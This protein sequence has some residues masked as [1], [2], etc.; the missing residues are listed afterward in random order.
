MDSR[1]LEYFVRIAEL[2]SINRAA[3]DLHIS[4][5][6]LSRHV[7]RLEHEMRASLFTRTRGGVRLTESGRLLADRVRPLL[8]QFATL[9]EEVGEQAAGQLSIGMP[10]PWIHLVAQPFVARYRIAQPA[11]RL[12]VHEGV[13]HLLRDQ[14]LAGTLD[15]CVLPVEAAP[16]PG[17]TQAA[18]LREPLVL[19][20]ARA[21]PSRPH[22]RT[23]RARGGASRAQASA[24]LPLATADA[25]PL[26]MPGPANPLRQQ[27]ETA[28]ARERLR[29]R[30]AVETDTL[31]MCLALAARGVG[32]TVV[33]A[34][35][36]QGAAPAAVD[37]DAV[38]WAPLGTLAVTWALAANA[39]RAHSLAVRE[40]ER[41]LDAVAR[42][43]ATGGA[44]PGAVRVG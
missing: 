13:S 7:A 32:A 22:A 27:V 3:A 9:R 33:P 24:A 21:M 14:L 18:L 4:Q 12:R 5:P 6:A 26:V 35:A 36:L 29:F 31:A 2:G 38:S 41:I 8:R 15:L 43:A 23:D 10:A 30:L 16:P 20:R 40:G 17:V 34:S 1:L 19:V 39:A 44:W 28:L 37:P 25:L 42:E 11:V